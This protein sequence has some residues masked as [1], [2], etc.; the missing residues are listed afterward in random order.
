METT[1]IPRQLP[2]LVTLGLLTAL[3]AH[4]VSYGGSHAVGG[5]YHATLLLLAFAGGG[6]LAVLA[7]GIAWTGARRRADG[8]VLAAE[9]RT[10]L[11]GPA[12]LAA[13]GAVWFSLI[14]WA[15]P[16]HALV[17]V[18]VIALALAAAALALWLLAGWA[19]RTI[20]DAAFR[21][22]RSPYRKRPAFR[23]LA[24]SPPPSARAVAFA[25]RRFSRPPPC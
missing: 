22:T 13:S 6:G 19:L 11:P 3:L 17:S 16:V 14:E 10:L 7:G 4:V 9:M 18:L 24:F 20:A 5:A 1:V 12:S 23:R 15:E 2:G 25:Y 21:I 8:S